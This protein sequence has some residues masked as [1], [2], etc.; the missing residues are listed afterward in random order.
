P[1]RS[2]PASAICGSSPPR[3]PSPIPRASSRSVRSG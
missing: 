3:T 1:R 2:S